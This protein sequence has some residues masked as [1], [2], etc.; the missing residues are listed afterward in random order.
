MAELTECPKPAFWSIF[1]EL[2]EQAVCD[3]SEFSNKEIA[4]TISSLSTQGTMSPL[5]FELSQIITMILGL[6]VLTQ[7]S[8]LSSPSNLVWL[9][10]SMFSTFYKYILE[11]YI[12]FYKLVGFG[13]LSYLV[14]ETFSIFFFI[15]F[16]FLYRNSVAGLGRGFKFHRP[17]E[18]QSITDF[19]DLSPNCQLKECTIFLSAWCNTPFNMS[20]MKV[21]LKRKHNGKLEDAEAEAGR[22]TTISTYYVVKFKMMIGDLCA[23]ARWTHAALILLFALIIQIPAVSANV[24]LI[25]KLILQC[26]GWAAGVFLTCY[27]YMEAASIAKAQLIRGIFNECLVAAKKVFFPRYQH[28]RE[29]FRGTM[30]S[31]R[32]FQNNMD[33]EFQKQRRSEAMRVVQVGD[34]YEVVHDSKQAFIARFR[35][36][37]KTVRDGL[38]KLLYAWMLFSLLPYI[39][40]LVQ[41]RLRRAAERHREEHERMG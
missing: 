40:H 36:V 31:L 30:V 19:P 33:E 5:P 12:T 10:K 26:P 41:R 13:R 14:F 17:R 2:A 18:V 32:K 38:F 23:R 29:T 24:Q 39:I 22:I 9:M 8:L 21:N 15:A 3:P 1:I 28:M 16:Y 25:P 11:P 4:H 37:N 6:M 20:A 34:E 27:R 35:S 7:A